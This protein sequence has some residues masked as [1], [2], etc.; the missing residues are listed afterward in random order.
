MAYS[1]SFRFGDDFYLGQYILSLGYTCGANC[2]RYIVEHWISYRSLVDWIVN[3]QSLV[4]FRWPQDTKW[5]R[6]IYFSY[7]L[8]LDL[9]RIMYH[10]NSSK[11][12]DILDRMECDW[13]WHGRWTIRSGIRNAW[14]AI[15]KRRKTFDSST[16]AY[17]WVRF[18]VL[19]AVISSNA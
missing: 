7:W 15:W 6:P 19:L 8:Q 3:S 4:T 17:W 13:I 11:Y 18:N 9:H 12:L 14:K 5:Q 2:I 1:L 16:N 10:R